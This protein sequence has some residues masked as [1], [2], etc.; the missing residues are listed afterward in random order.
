MS[1]SVSYKA[2]FR[3]PISE[4]QAMKDCAV[5][6]GAPAQKILVETESRDTFGNAYFTKVNLLMPLAVRHVTVVAGPNHS[7]ERLEYIFEKVFADKISYEFILH[8]DAL[9][10]AEVE[11]EQHALQILRALF[12][13][14]PSGLDKALYEVMRTLH[15][16]YKS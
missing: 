2:D 4:A 14:V 12:D 15:P 6:L 5:N 10:P 8:G 7:A 3:P 16:A 11:R 1:G 9:P 13:H